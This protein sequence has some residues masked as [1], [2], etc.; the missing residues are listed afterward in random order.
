MR[1]GLDWEITDNTIY[2]DDASHIGIAARN[3]YGIID[4]NTLIDS[5]VLICRWNYC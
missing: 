1:G 3:G 4:G 5:D 2:G